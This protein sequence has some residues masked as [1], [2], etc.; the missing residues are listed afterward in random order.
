ML[1]ARQWTLQLR[2]NTYNFIFPFIKRWTL[3]CV[4][5]PFNFLIKIISS[6][7]FP[8]ALEMIVFFAQCVQS[9]IQGRSFLMFDKNCAVEPSYCQPRSEIT[10]LTQIEFP[11][12]R[13]AQYNIAIFIFHF[14]LF[15][16]K[17][18]RYTK[19]FLI[20]WIIC[21]RFEIKFGTFSSF[22]NS[23]VTV[24][25]QMLGTTAPYPWEC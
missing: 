13:C 12:C 8:A 14:S 19:L 23:I 20:T 9:N 18:I 2:K 11:T 24:S 6:S 3:F 7:L 15:I 10:A 21:I 22:R 17:L 5:K 1:K 4:R 16:R 25:K